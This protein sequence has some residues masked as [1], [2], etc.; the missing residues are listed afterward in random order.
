M[1]A[2]RCEASRAP[3]AVEWPGAPAPLRIGQLVQVVPNHICS[4]FWNT[5]VSTGVNEGTVVGSW[6]TTDRKT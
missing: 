1:T 6:R 5:G 4:V 3:P 2:V